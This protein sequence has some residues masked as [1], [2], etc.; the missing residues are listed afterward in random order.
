MAAAAASTPWGQV[1]QRVVLRVRDGERTR[2]VLGE[3]LEAGPDRLVVSTRRGAVTVD[4]GAV[5]AG[6]PVPPAPVRAA[7][8]HRAPSALTLQRL[9]AEHWRAPER[10]PLGGWLLRAAGGFTRRANSVLVAGSVDDPVAAARATQRWYADR[11]LPAT[12]Q[13]AVPVA[14]DPVADQEALAAAGQA[15]ADGGWQELAP[16]WTA[17]MTAATG[18]LRAGGAPDLPPSLSL[19]AA[20]E[21]DEAWLALYRPDG[22]PPAGRALLRSAEEQRFLSVRGAEGRVAAVLRASLSS[23][24]AGVFGLTVSPP[25]RRQGLARVLLQGTASWAWRRGAGSV[26][27]QVLTSNEAARALYRDV[28]FTDHHTYRYLQHPPR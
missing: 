19:V 23:R 5:L 17:L 22:V 11:S 18:E 13:L 16:S 7:A 10:S 9:A 26:F 12:A 4:P 24:W 21:P 1:G 3:L 6:R 27:L 2:D 8:P 20:E 14:G 28:G 25:A 15:F